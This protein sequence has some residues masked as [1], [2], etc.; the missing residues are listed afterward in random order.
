MPE[1]DRLRRLE[2]FSIFHLRFK[3]HP[4]FPS[5]DKSNKRQKIRVS[6]RTHADSIRAFLSTVLSRCPCAQTLKDDKGHLGA[7]YFTKAVM[8]AARVVQKHYLLA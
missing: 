1:G 4:A 2:G 8:F 7:V 3:T 6:E 5:S